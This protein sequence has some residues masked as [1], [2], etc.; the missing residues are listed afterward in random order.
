MRVKYHEKP[1]PP[2]ENMSP[3]SAALRYELRM[4]HLAE[5]V[6]KFLSGHL[7]F[8]L[9]RAQALVHSCRVM[10]IGMFQSAGLYSIP[11]RDFGAARTPAHSIPGDL[12]RP[13]DSR[14][15]AARTA[16]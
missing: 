8:S 12:V 6:R 9:R 1:K 14:L 15:T 7:F 3:R 11:G 10:L 16:L 13:L 4:Q 2:P 5:Q